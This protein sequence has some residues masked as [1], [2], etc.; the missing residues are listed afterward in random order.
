MLPAN[1]TTFLEGHAAKV[2][3][4]GIPVDHN[5]SYAQGSAM[6]PWEIKKVMFH[7][8]GNS[9]SE[10]GV[11]LSDHEL[12]MSA[13]VLQHNPKTWFEDIEEC[14]K[15]MREFNR[16][17]IFIGGDHSITYPIIKGFSKGNK[18]LTILHIDAHPDLYDDYE[19]NPYSHASPFA[20]IM[21]K[22]LVKRLIQVGIRTLTAHQREQITK[23]GVECHEMRHWTGF[24]DLKLD[25]PTYMSIDMDGLDPA[26]APGV[27]HPE[28]G[29]LS[30]REVLDLVH[31]AG[32]HLVGGDV[33]EYNPTCDHNGITAIVGA[34][35]VRELAGSILSK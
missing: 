19:G 28:P 31:M 16:A 17:P 21:E 13:G 22:G 34:R 3:S 11:D 24:E 7:D 10:T 14:G 27:S 4:F 15:I 9:F 2:I 8:A 32:P 12:F 1:L 29:G 30:T 23:F 20:R 33:V 25:G 18:N 26:F 35:L 6:A 5:S